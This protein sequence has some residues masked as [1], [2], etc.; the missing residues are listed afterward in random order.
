MSVEM[1]TDIGTGRHG[2][3]PEADLRQD[4]ECLPVPCNYCF[5]ISHFYRHLAN[6]LRKIG[7]ISLLSA[8]R[9]N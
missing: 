1:R 2:W 3:R 6:G 9:K 5:Y 8:Q 4:V 7:K